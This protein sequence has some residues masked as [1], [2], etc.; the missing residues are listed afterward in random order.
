MVIDIGRGFAQGSGRHASISGRGHSVQSS[1][2]F[3]SDL[4]RFLDMPYAPGAR[5]QDG[6]AARECRAG[7]HRRR[8]RYGLGERVTVPP[9]AGTEIL[10][11]SL[12]VFRP[13]LWARIGWRCES[14]GDQGVIRA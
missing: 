10:S 14:C 4:C 3:V 6:R 11:G 1:P 12:V 8:G 13:D 9:A 2:M 5:P 7:G